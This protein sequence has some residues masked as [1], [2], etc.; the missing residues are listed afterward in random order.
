MTNKYEFK[1]T[2]QDDDIIGGVANNRVITFSFEV[3]S[4]DVWAVPLASFV[5]FLGSMYGYNIRDSIIIKTNM[6]TYLFESVSPDQPSPCSKETFDKYT[7]DL[8]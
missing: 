5:D 7:D 6:P 3:D 8:K 1:V 4:T 2:E